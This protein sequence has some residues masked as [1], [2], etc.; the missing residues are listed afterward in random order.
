LPEKI[1]YKVESVLQFGSYFTPVSLLG[2]HSLRN[3]GKNKLFQV[4]GGGWVVAGLMETALG[5]QVQSSI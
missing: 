5:N 4:G 3:V 1:A 2:Q